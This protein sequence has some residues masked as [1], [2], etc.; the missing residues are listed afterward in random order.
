MRP[1]TFVELANRYGVLVPAIGSFGSFAD[2]ASTIAT[3]QAVLRTAE[4][5]ARL[6]REVVEDAASDGAVW[7]ELSIWPGA[8]PP[9][10]GDYRARTMIVLEIGERAASEAGI[11]FGIMLAAVRDRGVEEAEELAALAAELRHIGVV[12]FGLDGDEASFPAL[13]FAEAFRI[14]REGGLLATPHAGE[15]SGPESV[16]VAAVALGADRILHGVRAID[17][18]DLLKELADRRVC[19][20]LCLTSNVRLSVVPSLEEHPL[21]RLLDAAVPCSLNADDPLLFRS[22]LLGEYEV[23]RD[24]LGLDDVWLAGIARS[25]IEYSGAPPETKQE[26]MVEINRWLQTAL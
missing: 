8:L 7:L 4:D 3:A 6:I 17:N 18:D 25:S 21:R 5:V 2:F 1:S 11:G 9:L 16:R 15:L 19:L 10:L 23:A 12:S 13:P 20:D 24:V 14:A 22:S 26:A